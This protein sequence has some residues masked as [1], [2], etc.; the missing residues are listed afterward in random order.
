MTARNSFEPVKYGLR[1]DE[2]GDALGGPAVLG[3]CEDAKWIKPVIHRHKLK[4]YAR[5][6]IARCW[7]RI[8]HGESPFPPSNTIPGGNQTKAHGRKSRT[9]ESV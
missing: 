7:L 2:A 8:E 5:T 4:V 9:P 3:A 6:D 1:R